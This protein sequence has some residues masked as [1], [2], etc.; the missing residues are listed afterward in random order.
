MQRLALRTALICAGKERDF[1]TFHC[2]KRACLRTLPPLALARCPARARPRP[3]HATPR[4]KPA[5]LYIVTGP[6]HVV[7]SRGAFQGEGV[8]M[9]RGRSASLQPE[10]IK[11]CEME[12]RM[13]RYAGSEAPESKRR[14]TSPIAAPTWSQ[15]SAECEHYD[16]GQ[17][18]C[19]TPFV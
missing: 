9:F 19:F 12:P 2:F 4:L 6:K 1:S 8:K 11:A 16:N 18:K 10:G 14:K 13:I 7:T 15:A 17:G 5:N 3:R